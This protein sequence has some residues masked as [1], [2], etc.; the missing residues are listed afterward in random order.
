ML[1]CL[2]GGVIVSSYRDL[3]F[4]IHRHRIRT[5]TTGIDIFIFIP[6]PNIASILD[7]R[8]L[9]AAPLPY[10]YPLHPSRLVPLTQ[11]LL[12]GLF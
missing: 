5:V 9:K 7:I 2:A 10:C 12:T 4:L 6:F 11:N 1:A 8:L 3:T